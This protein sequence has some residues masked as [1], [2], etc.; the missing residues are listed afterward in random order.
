[1]NKGGRY[2][3]SSSELLD[4]GQDVSEQCVAYGQLG[5]DQGS[6]DTSPTGYKYNKDHADPYALVVVALWHAAV[7]LGSVAA[8][9]VPE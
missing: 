3:D 2:D 6:K 8:N 1:M 7:N 5:E 9:T 4:N